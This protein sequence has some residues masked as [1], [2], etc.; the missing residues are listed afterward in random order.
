MKPIL[1]NT[2][3]VQAILEGRK[4]MTRRAVRPHLKVDESGFTVT[5]HRPTGEY[6]AEKTDMDG[7]VFLTRRPV[8]P[9]FEMGD[10]LYVRETFAETGDGSFIYRADDPYREGVKWK[11]CI[12]MPEYAARIYLKVRDVY[13]EKLQKICLSDIR[14]EGLKLTLSDLVRG[15]KD[16]AL[17]MCRKR[18]SNLWNGTVEKNSPYSW[19]SDPWVWVIKFERITEGGIPWTR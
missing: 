4:T 2:D 10:F 1:F 9:P 18:Y 5:L 14:D 8:K 15:G 7:N 17:K 12:H 16:E 6:R 19:D 3:M 13:I 11:P